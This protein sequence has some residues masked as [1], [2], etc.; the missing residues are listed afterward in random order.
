MFTCPRRPGEMWD[1]FHVDVGVDYWDGIRWEPIAGGTWKAAEKPPRVCS[2][3][4]CVN[5]EDGTALVT[6]G[7]NVLPTTKMYV[8]FLTPP[9]PIPEPI[10][11]VRLFLQHFNE[12]Q[13]N[14]FNEALAKQL[15]I[16]PPAE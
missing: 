13:A 3:C 8:R 16:S 14:A 11:A 4:G 15:R 10:P 2:F 5:P 9:P 12:E 1:R 7:W 6:A